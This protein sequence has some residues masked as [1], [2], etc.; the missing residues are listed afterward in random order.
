MPREDDFFRMSVEGWAGA[1]AAALTERLA[2]GQE[3]DLGDLP[4]HYLRVVE[5]PDGRMVLRDLVARFMQ[6]AA[7]DPALGFEN[8]AA[9]G[10]FAQGAQEAVKH[11]LGMAELA[12]TGKETRDG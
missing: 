4:A 10:F 1:Y 3:R 12:R 7:F 6:P 9:A 8:G 5:S 2:A 11:I